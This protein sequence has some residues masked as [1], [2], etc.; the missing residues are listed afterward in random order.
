M[1]RN[2]DPNRTPM[3][4][5]FHHIHGYQITW[6]IAGDG[7]DIR[8]VAYRDQAEHVAA[9]FARDGKRVSLYS[10]GYTSIDNNARDWRQESR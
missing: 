9:G 4:H 3:V 7:Y 10:W 5:G 2:D 1:L 8:L 6:R